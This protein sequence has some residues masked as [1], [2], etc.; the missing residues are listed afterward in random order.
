VEDSSRISSAEYALPRTTDE[1]QR[2]VTKP[3]AVIRAYLSFLAPARCDSARRA[4]ECRD[5]QNRPD[6]F[7]VLGMDRA[8]TAVGA[9]A[10]VSAHYPEQVMKTQARETT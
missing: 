4:G 3:K 5:R 10:R 1:M 6:R 2:I 8:N 9:Q 7:A